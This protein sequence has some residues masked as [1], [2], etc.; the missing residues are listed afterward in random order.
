VLVDSTGRP[1]K[2]S[3]APS[4][5]RGRAARLGRTAPTVWLLFIKKCRALAAYFRG[6]CDRLPIGA[7]STSEPSQSASETQHAFSALFRRTYVST[8]LYARR[9]LL[10]PCRK[11]VRNSAA[12]AA[13]PLA[14]A[15]D[16]APSSND[17]RRCSSIATVRR[18]R[19]DGGDRSTRRA[20]RS[21]CQ[22]PVAL[23][24]ASP[25]RFNNT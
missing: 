8:L 6:C 11:T 17:A 13:I 15:I 1:L 20:C 23:R 14:K 24:C 12:A 5:R 19:I 9:N 16:P 21:V 25:A 10:N 4:A 7:A 22:S 2:P 3:R 18:H